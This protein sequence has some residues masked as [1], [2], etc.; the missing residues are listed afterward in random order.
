MIKKISLIFLITIVFF[1]IFNLLIVF[2][3]P[4]YSKVN[5]N[6]HNYIEEQIKLLHLNNDDLIILHNE[7]WKN[8]HKFRFVPFIGHSEKNRTGKFVNFNEE[9]GRKVVR[10]QNCNTNIYLYGG[11]TTFGYNVTDDQTIGQHLQ[12]L[13]GD[14]E[15]VYNHGRAYFYSKQENNLFFLHLENKKKIHKAIFL[16]GINERCGSYVYVNY[17]NNSFDILVQRPYLMWKKS[18]V[19]FLHSLPISQFINS[20]FGKSRWINDHNNNILKISNCAKRPPL[21][22]LF[23]ARINQRHAVCENLNIQCFSFIQPFAGVHGVQI[24]KLLDETRKKNLIKKYT[25]LKKSNDYVKDL[26]YVLNEDS[27]LSYIDGVH[28]SPL[29]NKKIAKEISFLIKN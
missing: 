23:Q 26:S 4:I 12:N 24:K 1:I 19:N 2:S 22:E 15:C 3:W 16:D 11:S 6:K 21:N 18:F 14:E 28:Y 10:P 29:S 13:L 9:N 25:L 8:Y 7:T 20:M 5:S 27:T 17:L